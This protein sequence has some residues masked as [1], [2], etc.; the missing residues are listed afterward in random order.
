MFGIALRTN[1]LLEYRYGLAVTAADD[2]RL[3]VELQV[4]LVRAV[5]TDRP[6]GIIYGPVGRVVH[7][8]RGKLVIGRGI[9]RIVGYGCHEQ[10]P[11]PECV[12]VDAVALDAVGVEIEAAERI[13]RERLR[14]HVGTLRG[15]DEPA[16]EK[17][18]QHQYGC[19]PAHILSVFFSFMNTSLRGTSVAGAARVRL[20]VH[21]R[22]GGGTVRRSRSRDAGP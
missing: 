2:Q 3:A 12:V 13:C 10:P 16:A 1:Q 6:A 15:L 21:C 5:E 4:P 18:S 22:T 17:E 9:R 11:G 19:R 20:R 14:V 7:E 8:A